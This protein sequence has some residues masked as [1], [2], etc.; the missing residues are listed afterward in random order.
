MAESTAVSDL[1]DRLSAR[2][3]GGRPSRTSGIVAVVCWLITGT[4]VLL[5]GL[6]LVG[7]DTHVTLLIALSTA[8]PLVVLPGLVV[9]AG[10]L[11]VR[12]KA[13]SAAAVVVLLIVGAAWW[14][15]RTGKVGNG[16]AEA[17]RIRVLALNV[18]FNHD[19]GAAVSRQIRA[20]NPDVV[21]LSELS[22]MTLRHLDLQQYPYSWQR[23]E[24]DAFG[25]GV[26]SRWPLVSR[27]TWTSYERTMI[28][29]TVQA[30]TGQFRLYQV[31]TRSPVG[32]RGRQAWKA[33][34]KRLQG[35]LAAERLPVV[36]AGDFNA[37]LWDASFREVLG[38]RGGM[39]DAGAGRG[40]L[41]TWPSGKRL[42]PPV[43]PLDH[44]LVSRGIGVRNIRVLGPVGSDHRALTADLA[45]PSGLS[46]PSGT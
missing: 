14:P 38:G 8:W 9:V 35:Y 19:T 5:S 27:T 42:V 31:H 37:S 26:W 1:R 23:P 22:A 44:I 46:G 41:A 29:M 40:Y 20:E 10:A 21:V 7:L 6:R 36:A 45:L 30:P 2:V 33:Q 15:C 3:S 11:F 28:T 17:A 4:L 12:R 32:Q 24:E 16:P 25:Q 13:L 34:F 43:L 18:Q 39:A